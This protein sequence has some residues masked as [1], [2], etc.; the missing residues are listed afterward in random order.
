MRAWPAAVAGAALW[1]AAC[2]REQGPGPI[3]EGKRG[4]QRCSA[5]PG[6]RNPVTPLLQRPFDGQFPVAN[7]FDHDFPTAGELHPTAEGESQLSYCGVELLGV[8]NGYPGYGFSLPEGTPVLS[9]AP[10]EVTFAGPMAAFV[11]PLNGKRFDDQ[12]AVTVR[13]DTLGGVGYL[14]RYVHLGSLTVK[15]GDQVLAG[16]R[17]GVSG[18]SGCTGGPVLFFQVLRLTGTRTGEPTPVDPYGWDGPEQDPWAD[19]P[20]GMASA[21]L[22]KD[23]E[24]PTLKAR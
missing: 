14:T 22:W 13:H 11:C 5:R 8:V 24:A 23:G 7:V 2:P 6:P 18:R 4:A 17:V 16:Q 19:H 15:A 21:Y 9:A 10:G 1:L 12:L 20:R 3:R